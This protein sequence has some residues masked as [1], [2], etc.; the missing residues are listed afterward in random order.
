MFC[1]KC[2]HE[3]GVVSTIAG[4]VTERY[5]RCKNPECNYKF[6]S[7]EIAKYDPY[8]KEYVKDVMK[9]EKIG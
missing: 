3:T 5:R 2:G 1:P 8:L 7:V 9:I 6:L 4:N